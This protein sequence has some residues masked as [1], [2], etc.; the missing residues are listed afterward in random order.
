MGNSTKEIRDIF[1]RGTKG[2]KTVVALEG[3]SLLFTNEDRTILGRKLNSSGRFIDLEN[4]FLNKSA[5]LEVLP[6]D[7][8]LKRR[9]IE[10]KKKEQEIKSRKPTL[11]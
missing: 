6:M 8:Y 1:D 2:F 3:G 10:G 5:V 9:E 4:T 11:P 7:L